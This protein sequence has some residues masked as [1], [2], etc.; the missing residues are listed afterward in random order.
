MHRSPAVLALLLLTFSFSA[1]SAGPAPA[2]EG[3]RIQL[4]P[5]DTEGGLP[6][7]Q[8]LKARHSSRSFSERSLPDQVLSDL[9]WAAFGVNR[10]ESGKRT[11]PSAVNWQEIDIYVSTAEGLYLYEPGDHAL[12]LVR[13]E[14]LR[15]L[16]GEQAF[17]ATAPVNLIYVADYGRIGQGAMGDKDFYAA[18]DTGF[19]AQNVYLF[20][21]SEGLSVVV[22]AMIDRPALAQ[23][24]GLEPDQHITLSQTVGYPTP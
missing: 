4:P 5:P 12:S 19:I 24:M 13:D 8:A 21:A 20:C 1:L 22:R 9:L 10:P 16:A 6:L 14:D 2:Q 3:L 17:V 18:A 15:A 11:A 23:A 7:M